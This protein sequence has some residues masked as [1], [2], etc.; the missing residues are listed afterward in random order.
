L[1][2]ALAS[3]QP[4]LSCLL[5][6]HSTVPREPGE[7]VITAGISW[8][9]PQRVERFEG[10][11][12]GPVRVRSR[13]R[14]R[15]AQLLGLIGQLTPVVVPISVVLL[16]FL[17]QSRQQRYTH[18]RNAWAAM[19]PVSHKNNNDLYV[20]LLSDVKTFRARLGEL[21]AGAND[22]EVEEAFFYLLQIFGN[23]RQISL[24]GGFYLQQRAGEEL[25][26]DLWSVFLRRVRAHLKPPLALSAAIDRVGAK[27]SFSSYRRKRER[28]DRALKKEGSAAQATGGKLPAETDPVAERARLFAEF[29]TWACGSKSELEIL[30]LFESVLSY[31]MNRIYVFWYG[32]AVPL[33]A[34][35]AREIRRRGEETGLDK[36]LRVRIDAWIASRQGLLARLRSR[37][38]GTDT[39]GAQAKTSGRADTSTAQKGGAEGG[40]KSP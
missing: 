36:A 10:L 12:L 3:L 13:Q 34:E 18:E 1:S 30:F 16:G 21:G 38:R 19:L 33:A 32:S 9:G 8:T 29:K 40:K 28:L 25:V 5:T 4:G 20:P 7:Y 2:L 17:F 31:E 35:T 37:W 27:D 15:L 39:T 6:L 14:E 23:M 11:D 22:D 24:Q 26:T